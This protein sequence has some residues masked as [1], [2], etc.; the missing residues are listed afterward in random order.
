VPTI[1]EAG[2]PGYEATNWW[3]MVAPAGT[4]RP[5]IERLHKEL[6]VILASA[7]TK[8]RFET[9]GGEAAQM[10]PEEFGR[11]ITSETVKWAKVVKRSRHQAGVRIVQRLKTIKAFPAWQFPSRNLRVRQPGA[12]GLARLL[13]VCAAIACA[14]GPAA[15]QEP[16]RNR[17]LR[18][19]RSPRLP[20]GKIRRSPTSRLQGAVIGEVRID[21]RNIFRSR[22]REGK[23]HPLP[24]GERD[25]HSNAGLGRQT[26][27]AVQARR[28]RL[29]PS[30]RRD[31]ATDAVEPDFYDVSIVPVAY[32]NG[33]VD[34]EVKTL[35]TWTAGARSERQPRGG[36]QQSGWSLRDTNA[37]GTGVL[38]GASRTSDADRSGTSTR[39]RT[40]TLST[41]GTSIDLT[42]S[43]LSDGQTNAMSI[44]R[45]FYAMDTRWAAGFFGLHGHSH[46]LPSSATA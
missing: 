7:E 16:L 24:R 4:P 3:G 35:D 25:S 6:S 28:A 14:L 10:S 36:R 2:V 33:V 37:L 5:V 43:R 15:A 29:G 18:S 11:F 17:K 31:G 30:H 32:Q 45:P 12:A 44:V 27:I 1:S 13:A 9:E 41:A 23:R 21:N 40:P 19:L 26:Q 22:G 38:I 8:K 34:I 46:R 20:A 39:S 42:H